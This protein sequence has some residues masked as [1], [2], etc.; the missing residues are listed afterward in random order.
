MISA[1]L[2][3]E[4]FDS[5]NTRNYFDNFKTLSTFNGVCNALI[6]KTNLKKEQTKQKT[7]G[8]QKMVKLFL[9]RVPNDLIHKVSDDCFEI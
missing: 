4:C 2:T 7:N 8:K 6:K 1:Q 9:N 3:P 5:T